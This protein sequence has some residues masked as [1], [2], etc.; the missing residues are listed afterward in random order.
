[1]I[2]LHSRT[3]TK[4][5]RIG[6]AARSLGRFRGGVDLYVD[7]LLRHLAPVAH[8]AGHRVLALFDD[9]RVAEQFAPVPVAPDVVRIRRTGK[10]LWDHLVLPVWCRSRRVDVILCPRSFRPLVLPC[11]SVAVIYDL[12]YF[13]T[14]DKLPW[15]DHTYFRTLHR[16][17]LH[18]CNAVIAFSEFTVSRLRALVPRLEPARI[19]RLPPGRPHDLF[20]RPTPE[21][22]ELKSLSVP[23]PFILVVGARPWK[24]V[25]RI[26]KAFARIRHDI[27]HSLVIAS[28]W[29]STRRELEAVASEQGIIDR[30]HFLG[31]VDLSELVTLYRRASLFVYASLYEGI[32]MP[33]LEAMACGCPVVASSAASVPEVT[34][35]AA[36][37]VDPLDVG[38]IS[39]G[40]R[41][42]LLDPTLQE[43]LRRKGRKRV[44]ELSWDNVARSVLNLITSLS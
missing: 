39:N 21:G 7:R 3:D 24:N 43:E 22:S 40:M 28:A 31:R 20:F 33:P 25:N 6:F 10:L 32:G 1:M 11:R 23:T 37:L 26:V 8:S 44:A 15:W 9:P 38:S 41:K 36:L 4:A 19:H 29:E 27:E 34:A 13:D 30:V 18:R 14:Q 12:L 16:L 35:G 17:S 42:A 2:S 5:L